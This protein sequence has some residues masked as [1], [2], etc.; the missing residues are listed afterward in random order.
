[1]IVNQIC[2]NINM[3]TQGNINYLNDPASF[4]IDKSLQEA[5]A[6]AREIGIIDTGQNSI[7]LRQR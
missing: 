2:Y 4:W 3:Q 6:V 7:Q 5:K 1:M